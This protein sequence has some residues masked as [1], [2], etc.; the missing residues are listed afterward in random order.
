MQ[1][2]WPETAIPTEAEEAALEAFEANQSA[3]PKSISAPVKPLATG[4]DWDGG[5]G[6]NNAEESE[7]ESEEEEDVMAAP[8]NSKSKKRKSHTPYQD[9]TAEV[10]T[11]TPESTAEFERAILASPNS[12]M[13]WIQYMAFQMELSEIGKARDI[14]RRALNKIGFREEAEKLNVWMALLNLE[15]VFSTPAEL[16]KVFKEAVQ[17]ND[18]KAVYLRMAAILQESNKFDV[19]VQAG[20]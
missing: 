11:K 5:A 2:L 9:L 15:N 7:S 13:L 3:K 6:P 14:G 10:H 17:Y 20:F 8:E 4:F 19:S 12:S 1:E 18:A 16:E